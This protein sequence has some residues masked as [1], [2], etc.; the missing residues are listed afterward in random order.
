MAEK[1]AFKELNDKLS[2]SF[3]KLRQDMIELK[4]SKN[5]LENAVNELNLKQIEAERDSAKEEAVHRMKLK[6]ESIAY[7]HKSVKELSDTIVLLKKDSVS[8]GEFSRASERA[9]AEIASLK[10]QISALKKTRDKI[11]ESRITELEKSLLKLDDV[12]KAV[13][14]DIKRKYLDAEEVGAELKPLKKEFLDLYNKVTKVKR[15]VLSFP[16]LNFFAN[17]CLAVALLGFV[18]AAISLYMSYTFAAN[19]FGIEGIVVLAIGT[20]A[21]LAVAIGK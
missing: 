10:K 8:R 15:E 11:K 4:K 1:N 19:F 3:T 13:M 5:F 12:K 20:A 2:I 9:E 21:K 17:A 18:G 6:V 16:K 14:K 7:E